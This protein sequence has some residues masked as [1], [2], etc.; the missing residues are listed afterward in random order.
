MARKASKKPLGKSKFTG[1]FKQIFELP[2]FDS[3]ISFGCNVRPK[4][5][6]RLVTRVKAFK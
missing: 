5:Q 4:G 2:F 6:S 3:E 1:E